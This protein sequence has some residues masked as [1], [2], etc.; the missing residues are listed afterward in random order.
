MA[1]SMDSSVR[2][3]MNEEDY[4]VLREYEGECE[5]IIEFLLYDKTKARDIQNRYETDFRNLPQNGQRVTY[6]L[7]MLTNSFADGITAV[8]IMLVSFILIM[9]AG[10]NLRFTIL[11]TLEE[12]IR[13]IGVMKAIGIWIGNVLGERVISVIFRMLNMGLVEVAFLKVLMTNLCIQM[14]LK[15]GH[16][17]PLSAWDTVFL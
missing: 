5:Y 15:G 3:L 12:E 14:G 1:A 13:E 9:I 10:I 8:V 2:F 4:Q 11:A 17:F 6:N 7:L 16:F